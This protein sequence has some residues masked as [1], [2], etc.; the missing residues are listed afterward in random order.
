MPTPLNNDRASQNLRAVVES[1]RNHGRGTMFVGEDNVSHRSTLGRIFKA[2]P[3]THRQSLDNFKALL[4]QAYPSASARIDAVL[5]PSYQTG[6]LTTGAVQRAYQQSHDSHKFRIEYPPDTTDRSARLQFED[7]RALAVLQDPKSIFRVCDTA[8]KLA[9][10]IENSGHFDDAWA[11]RF[12]EAHLNSRNNYPVHEDA[13]NIPR[14]KAGLVAFLRDTAASTDPDRHVLLLSMMWRLPKA[15]GTAEDL[16]QVKLVDKLYAT[17]IQEG[18]QHVDLRHRLV[19]QTR[20]L[21]EVGSAVAAYIEADSSFD[22]SSANRL[23]QKLVADAQPLVPAPYPEPLPQ[24]KAE[25]IGFFKK[26][27]DANSGPRACILVKGAL[28]LASS[29]PESERKA[30]EKLDKFL[31]KDGPHFTRFASLMG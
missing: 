24:T 1:A 6:R 26:P 28:R 27:I 2:N 23:I 22:D 20:V 5:Q 13:G 29:L 19:E 7:Q 8:Q 16:P 18:K 17:K 3:I 4:N 9:T 11:D 21:A 15:V 10:H 31:S 30:I 14:T 25:L 12:L